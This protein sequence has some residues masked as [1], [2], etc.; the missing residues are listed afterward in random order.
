MPDLRRLI[1]LAAAL[2]AGA[3]FADLW[4]Y[5]DEQGHSHVANRQVDARY[6]LFF[7]G[8]TTLDVPRG[9]A[10][11]RTRAIDALAGTPLYQHATDPARAQRYAPLI[12]VNARANGLDPALVKA[13]VAVESAFDPHAISGKGAVGLM[14]VL[15]VTGERYGITGDARRSALDKLLDPAINVRVGT[16]YLHDLLARFA[17]DLSLA[18]A[19]YN[20][21]EGAVALHNNSVPPFDETRDYVKLVQALYAIYR[22][23]PAAPTGRV[24]IIKPPRHTARTASDM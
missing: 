13:V 7:R 18:L 24:Q 10:D 2:H 1:A 23:L 15:P 8:E 14:Q 6:K 20:A 12:E 11:E 17:N 16:R 9:P 3:A 22:P 5:V 19:A 4:A 21:G